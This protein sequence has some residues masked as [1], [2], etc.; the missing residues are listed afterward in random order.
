MRIPRY[1][2]VKSLERVIQLG[3]LRARTGSPDLM[4][5]PLSHGPV[6]TEKTMP[7]SPHLGRSNLAQ[8]A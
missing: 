3:Y 5:L 7:T 2:E 1:R 6:A 4:P 8:P